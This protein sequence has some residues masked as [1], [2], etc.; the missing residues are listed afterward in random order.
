MKLYLG[1]S[2]DICGRNVV[3]VVIVCYFVV[4]HVPSTCRQSIM[5]PPHAAGSYRFPAEYQSISCHTYKES[6]SLCFSLFPSSFSFPLA[7]PECT[8]VMTTEYWIRASL[9]PVS[10]SVACLQTR[11]IAVMSPHGNWKNGSTACILP[12]SYLGRKCITWNVTGLMRRI[13]ACSV[14][15][16]KSVTDWSYII[17]LAHT[18]RFK[19]CGEIRMT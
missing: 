7:T 13:C 6:S 15:H 5:C 18:W 19:N 16:L 14:F 4:D 3:V 8:Y 12:L 10:Q 17:P 2:D 11:S 1:F 9:F